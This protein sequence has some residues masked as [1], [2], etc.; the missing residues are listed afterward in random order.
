MFS[1]MSGLLPRWLMMFL[2]RT[3]IHL[4]GAHRSNWAAVGLFMLIE[5]KNW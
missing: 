5:A 1:H 4:H 2:K 3:A